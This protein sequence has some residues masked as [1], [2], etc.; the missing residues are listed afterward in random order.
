M[1]QKFQMGELLK[2]GDFMGQL[3]GHFETSKGEVE[4]YL[5][6]KSFVPTRTGGFCQVDDFR[7]VKD[8]KL[9]ERPEASQPN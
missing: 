8:E 6:K 3:C 7:I 1:D 9:C 2:C 5:T 4:L